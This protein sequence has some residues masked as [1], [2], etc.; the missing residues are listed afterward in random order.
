MPSVRPLAIA[1]LSAASLAGT[2]CGTVHLKPPPPPPQS[3]PAAEEA[4]VPPANGGARV[5]V[6]TDV[7]ARVL[8]ASGGEVTT[9]QGETH[10]V[11]PGTVLCTS[12]PCSLGMPYGDYELVLEGIGSRHQTRRSFVPVHVTHATEVVNHTLGQ[13]SVSIGKPLGVTF[14]LLG[15]AALGIALGVT[16]GNMRRADT[17]MQTFAIAGATS[18][19]FGSTLYFVSPFVHQEGSTTQWTP[20]PTPSPRGPTVGGGLGVRF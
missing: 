10:Y 13:Q 14:M 7:P 4:L 3:M 17:G 19:A 9:A 8:L 20:S 2:G 16:E 6:T 12:T 5:L 18:I 15:A 11:E 1:L